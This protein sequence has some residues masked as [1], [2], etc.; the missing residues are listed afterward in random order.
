MATGVGRRHTV[1][2]SSHGATY[3][4]SG[5]SA[6]QLAAAVQ[7]AQR[8][9]NTNSVEWERLLG[10]PITLPDND[11]ADTG[12]NTTAAAAAATSAFVDAARSSSSGADGSGGCHACGRGPG[13][14]GIWGGA[15][16]KQVSGEQSAGAP[17]KRSL[18]SSAPTA[19]NR[20]SSD[21]IPVEPPAADEPL[22][23]SSLP[24]L[25]AR[26]VR[27]ATSLGSAMAPAVASSD[28]LPV[29]MVRPRRDT[30]MAG[31]NR[32]VAG[33]APPPKV[34]RLQAMGLDISSRLHETEPPVRFNKRR[35]NQGDESGDCA[36]EEKAEEV[37]EAAPTE[38]E[39]VD[40]DEVPLANRVSGNSAGIGAGK[41]SDQTAADSE[42]SASSCTR[43]GSQRLES[44]PP[45][46]QWRMAACG[47]DIATEDEDEQ[48]DGN[49]DGGDGDD[50]RDEP[51][52]E[53][54]R[55][56]AARM[57]GT[58]SVRLRR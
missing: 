58:Q 5:L 6:A 38:E 56:R 14:G 3:W 27:S 15:A 37:E 19:I 11:D 31:V 8:K 28:E 54:R 9:A 50:E 47:G 12:T 16:N 1:T 10:V 36:E 26:A 20:R 4:C 24:A 30:A 49:G 42:M 35:R 39:D 51:P 44:W 29:S 32:F 25:P 53:G 13:H 48:A 43:A 46:D 21:A 18:R 41:V 34:A 2:F 33:A 45:A 22:L 40:D 7:A 57:A 55:I 17:S 52:N 23:P